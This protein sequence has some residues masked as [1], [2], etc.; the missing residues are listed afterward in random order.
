MKVIYIQKLCGTETANTLTANEAASAQGA[1]QNVE[2]VEIR[3]DR[4]ETNLW[5]L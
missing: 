3:L 5:R 2:C 1:V 4:K